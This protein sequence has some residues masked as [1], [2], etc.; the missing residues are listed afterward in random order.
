MVTLPGA[1][2]YHVNVI[3]L[4]WE[5]IW[6]GGLPQILGVLHVSRPLPRSQ[7][8]LL[9][10][11]SRLV[12]RVG[13]NPGNVVEQALSGCR[14]K[15]VE[16]TLKYHSIHHY[17]TAGLFYFL[18]IWVQYKYR[19]RCISYNFG[20]LLIL[21]KVQNCFKSFQSSSLH[22]GAMDGSKKSLQA[23]SSFFSH[24]CSLRTIY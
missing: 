24:F 17:N 21:K 19:K 7:G 13:E 9:P 14:P 6:T 10:A 15:R 8:S 22:L 20:W 12:G 2:T 4:K 18:V 1:P 3:K 23:S 16:C 5:I 11:F